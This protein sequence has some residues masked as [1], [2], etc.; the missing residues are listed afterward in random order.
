MR[1]LLLWPL[2]LVSLTL[3]WASPSASADD[4]PELAGTNLLSLTGDG[5]T[6][7]AADLRAAAERAASTASYGVDASPAGDAGYGIPIQL[8]AARL[9]PQVAVSYGSGGPVTELGRGWSVSVG[10]E[11]TQARGN[12]FQGYPEGTY[13]VQGGGLSGALVPTSIDTG[14]PASPDDVVWVSSAPGHVASTWVGVTGSWYLL[15]GGLTHQLDRRGG[16]DGT[17]WGVVSTEDTSGNRIDVAYDPFN[18]WRIDTI[19]YGGTA[20]DPHF[21]RVRFVYQP[22]VATTMRTESGAVRMVS[23]RLASIEVQTSYGLPDYETRLRYDFVYAGHPITYTTHTSAGGDLDYALDEYL[24]EVHLVTVGAGGIDTSTRVLAELDYT[25]PSD[26]YRVVYRDP[27]LISRS[28]TRSAQVTALEPPLPGYTVDPDKVRSFNVWST[29]ETSRQLTDVTGDGLPEPVAFAS[30]GH[31][32]TQRMLVGATSDPFSWYSVEESRDVS[33]AADVD[34]SLGRTVTVLLDNNIVNVDDASLVEP[35]EPL[36]YGTYGMSAWIDVDGD[37][38]NDFVVAATESELPQGISLADA[39]VPQQNVDYEDQ[40]A[41]STAN[42]SW[43]IWYGTDS[44]M[45]ETAYTVSAPFEYLSIQHQ[46]ATGDSSLPSADGPRLQLMDLDGDGW[47]DLVEARSGNI[48]VF[49]HSGTRGGGWSSSSTIVLQGVASTLEERFGTVGYYYHY[50]ELQ[51]Y[52]ASTSVRAGFRDVT[53]DG[54]V[55]YVDAWGAPW[56]VY[57]NLGGAFAAPISW[58]APGVGISTT[59]EAKPEVSAGDCVFGALPAIGADEHE[60]SSSPWWGPLSSKGDPLEQAIA[61][62]AGD[63]ISWGANDSVGD[64]V[65]QGDPCANGI[66]Q[67]PSRAVRGLLDLDGDGLQDLVHGDVGDG[68]WYRNL[69][70]GFDLE[71]RPLPAWFPT[72]DGDRV[73]GVTRPVQRISLSA[74]DITATDEMLRVADVNGDGLPDVIDATAQEMIFSGVASGSTELEDLVGVRPGLLASVTLG[75]GAT[76]ELDYI[77]SSIVAPAGTFDEHT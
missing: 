33:T 14:A 76:T 32:W 65:K 37:G 17:S 13:L 59:H 28:Y 40:N 38:F 15:S 23:D 8:P 56:E 70:S 22:A 21:L 62:S 18:D 29:S 19:S 64:V 9:T 24:V 69:G 51:P 63:S 43:S 39:P 72:L 66:A 30:G 16:V 2:M 11:I 47:Q 58:A 68:E 73:L 48:S 53:G 34:E 75:T 54:L 5:V 74:E 36:L 60:E 42:T 26:D 10:P 52:V 50:T 45:E 35:G 6:A 71:P 61:D 20:S 57:V 55:D 31:A 44:G 12:H 41:G 4:P 67:V 1:F 49:W 46:I 77:A 7:S 25:T 27:E 3:L